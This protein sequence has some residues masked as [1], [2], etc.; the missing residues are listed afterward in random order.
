VK[1]LENKTKDEIEAELQKI[2]KERETEN[3]IKILEGLYYT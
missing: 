2:R 1:R 3:I